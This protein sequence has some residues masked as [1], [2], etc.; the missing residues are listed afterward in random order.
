MSHALPDNE[1]V[2]RRILH[3]AA[4]QVEP[5]ADGLERIQARLTNPRPVPVAWICAIGT[6]LSLRIPPGLRPAIDRLAHEIRLATEHFMPAPSKR[7]H[8][9]GSQLRLG[10]LRPFAAMGTAVFIV[11]AVVYISIDVTQVIAPAGSDTGAQHTRPGGAGG[12]SSGAGQSFSHGSGPVTSPGPSGGLF[13]T[14]PACATPGPAK[15]T[16]LPPPASTGPTKGASPTPSLTATPTPTATATPTP[17]ATAT[18]SPTNPGSGT[19]SSPSPASDVTADRQAGTSQP[20]SSA[21][22]TTTGV[23]AATASR[24]KAASPAESPCASAKPHKKKETSQTV[25]PDGTSAAGLMAAPELTGTQS[26]AEVKGR[27]S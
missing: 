27:L 13:K 2:L 5:S 8:G 7:P 26:P 24:D 9:R 18:S 12:A 25:S 14:T 11:A 10:W 22:A 19:G 6:W 23:V 4:E 15:S 20:S 17:T 16:I 1:A 21:P 3:A